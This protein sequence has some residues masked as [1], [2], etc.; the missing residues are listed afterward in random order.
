MAT[1]I[2]LKNGSG[3]PDAADLVQGEVALDLTNKRIYSENAS[4][5]VIEMGTSPST[6]DINAGTID[7]VTMATS[8]IT[9]GAGKTLDVSAGTLTLAND[10]ISGDKIQGGTIGSVTI[11]T[12]TA[13]SADINGGTIDGTT[14]GGASA[15]AITG[16]TI[17][18]TSFVTSGDMTFGDD[19]KAIFGAGSDLQIYHSGTSSRIQDLGTGNLIIDTDGTEIQ[20][21]SGNISQY[22]LRAVKDGAVTLYHNGTAN[23]R[24]ATTATGVNVTGNVGI[25]TS[26]PLG[27]LH[28]SNTAGDC[29]AYFQSS[30]S[31]LGQLIFSDG[32][33]AGKIAYRHATN[34]LEVTVNGSERLRID[35]SGN[36]LV[37]TT[38][39]GRQDLNS[40]TIEPKISG[41][42]YAV[43]NHETGSSSGRQYIDFAF[44]GTQIGSITQSGT[45]AVAYN[46]SSDYR[47]KNITGPITNSGNYIDSLNPVEGTWKADGST[48]VGLIAHEVQEA[49]RTPVATGE[50]DGEEMQG[51]D[52]SSAEIIANLIAEVKALRQR[53]ATLESN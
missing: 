36:L 31:G 20:L 24:L 34:A 30:A 3:A 16:T 7:G 38:T 28:V 35:S 27:Q 37:G 15:G 42:G 51:M 22:M 40:I 5:T 47:L 8:D 53:V 32:A 2:K 19:D 43:F 50:K 29:N 11:S 33:I 17:T 25:G 10:Q 6:I 41:G 12:L 48:F 23:P 45:T 49:S 39:N 18:G 4:G 14:I 13:T 26:S 46:T 1:T 52:Y 44:G 21:T 9:V